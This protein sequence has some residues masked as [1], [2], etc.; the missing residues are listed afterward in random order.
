MKNRAD[1]QS[2]CDE[3]K[4]MNNLYENPPDTSNSCAIPDVGTI[5]N[6]IMRDD[7]FPSKRKTN[8]GPIVLLPDDSGM[9]ATNIGTLSI[10]SLLT[11]GRTACTLHGVNKY[12]L[13]MSATYDEGGEVRFMKKEVHASCKGTIV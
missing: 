11:K 1:K 12:L 13:Q 7:P 8:N 9:K 4:L 2:K 10:P 5:G 6:C 3:K